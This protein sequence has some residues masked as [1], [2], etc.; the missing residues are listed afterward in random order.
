MELRE[1]VIFEAAFL[2]ETMNVSKRQKENVLAFLK[3]VWNRAVQRR[4]GVGNP[5][6]LWF[7]EDT[8]KKAAE[9]FGQPHPPILPSL[10]TEEEADTELEPK[11]E[12]L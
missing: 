3:V 4:G 1:D 6:D 12:N 9:Y 5:L 11:A 7:D 8:V 10:L 2:Y